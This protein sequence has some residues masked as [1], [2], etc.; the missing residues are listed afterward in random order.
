MNWA[1][2]QSTQPLEA[3]KTVAT[4]GKNETTQKRCG[5]R[6]RP[7][8]ATAAPTRIPR[9]ATGRASESLLK[10]LNRKTLKTEQPERLL[11]P[12]AAA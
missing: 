4:M 7:T 10:S 11:N 8:A 1:D 6:S 5:N 3:V 12:F 9:T 2:V